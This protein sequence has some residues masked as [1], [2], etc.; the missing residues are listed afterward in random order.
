[1]TVRGLPRPAGS[2]PMLAAPSRPPPLWW[3]RCGTVLIPLV[4]LLAAAC[5][6]DKEP[7]RLPG[8]NLGGE[9]APD[10]RLI[11][12]AGRSVALSGLRGRPVVLTFLYSTCPDFC[13]LTAEKLRQTY[14]QLGKD[15]GKVSMLAVSV[16]PSGDTPDAVR[17]FTAVHR[18]PDANWH[19]LIGSEAELAP[20]W[21]AYGIARVQTARTPAVGAPLSDAVGHTE[22][23]FLLDTQGRKQTLLR[24]DFDPQA[25]ARA[26]I[27]LTK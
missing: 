19:Y 18:L 24:G 21:A 1:M 11:D 2:T 6:G 12:Q 10:F 22:A 23:L 25:L 17:E 5:G 15:A 27:T 7:A 3:H 20:V 8:T 13:P 4:C 9:P 16:D 26:L 14:E